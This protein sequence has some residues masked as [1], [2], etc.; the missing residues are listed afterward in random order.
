MSLDLEIFFKNCILIFD[1]LIY[2]STVLYLHLFA[3]YLYK[4]VLSTRFYADFR[5]NCW[6]FFSDAFILLNFQ[7][8]SQ[9]QYSLARA[10]QSFKSLVQIHEKN[11]EFIP[12]FCSLYV[13][14]H[15]Y[16]TIAAYA[17]LSLIWLLF[18]LNIP[19]SF[20]TFQYDFNGFNDI[21]DLGIL[22]SYYIC[23]LL[24]VHVLNKLYY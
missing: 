13:Y 4:R 24:S 19:R 20:E 2:S 14:Y 23:E 9:G 6:L 8:N 10:Q 22:F 15:N 5:L 11:G 18:Q 16:S 7:F 17:S 12:R 3:P 1:A 21:S